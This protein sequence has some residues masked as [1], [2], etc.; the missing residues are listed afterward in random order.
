MGQCGVWQNSLEF[1]CTWDLGRRCS[2]D[3]SYCPPHRHNNWSTHASLEEM[4]SA[5]QLPLKYGEI[6]T[7]FSKDDIDL[8]ISFTGG[9]P[10]LNPDFLNLCHYIKNEN[11]SYRVGVTTNGLFSNEYAEDLSRA[12][13]FITLSYHFEASQKAK[14]RIFAVIE[15]LDL[16]SKSAEHRL[17]DFNINVMVHAQEN[18]FKECQNLVLSLRERNIRYSLREIGEHPNDK[19]AHNYSEEQLLFLSGK[20]KY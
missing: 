3:C 9:E 1:A 19:G 4:K 17:S 16:M 2:L 7:K 18:Y 10:T 8:N 11:P 13:D 20:T 6:F 15:I 5:A 12:V 14:E